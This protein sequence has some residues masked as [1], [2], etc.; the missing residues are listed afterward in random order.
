M[1]LISTL[2]NVGDTEKKAVNYL[3]YIDTQ[4]RLFQLPR[5]ITQSKVFLF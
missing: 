2:H 1:K 3:W 4:T 5:F